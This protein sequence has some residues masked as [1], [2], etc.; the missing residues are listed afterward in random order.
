MAAVV[1]AGIGS[2]L[3]G[4]EDFGVGADFG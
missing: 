3:S 1:G 2:E 4:A